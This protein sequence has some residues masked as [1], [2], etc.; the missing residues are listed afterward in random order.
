MS[1]D[2]RPG[3][4]GLALAE[5]SLA[6]V[7]LAVVV[8][9]GRLYDGNDHLADLVTFT[10]VAHVLAAGT[11]RSRLSTPVTAAIG[12]AGAVLV[13]TWLLFGAT[14]RFGL[15]T[16]ATVDAVG[17]ALDEAGPAFR[18][19]KAP[20]EVLVGFQLL[21]G[22]ALWGAAWFADWAAFRLRVAAEA[23]APAMILFVF[24]TVL[25]ADEGRFAAAVLFG[26][27]VV[28]FV[29]N[30][31]AMVAEG[32]AAWMASTPAEGARAVRRAAIGLGAAAVVLGAL[33]APIGPGYRDEPLVQWREGTGAGA[34]R[35]TVSPIV[36]LRRR[37]VSQSSRELFEVESP[38]AAYWRLT[39]L[40]QFDG[41]IWSSG[42]DFG[43]ADETLE[44][45]GPVAADT[46]VFTQQVRV[47]GLAAIW[48]PAAYQARVLHATNRPVRWNA[49]SSTLIV[50]ASS[51]SSDGL[52]Y[53]VTSARPVLDPATLERASGPDPDDVAE[54]YLALPAD[55]P[56]LAAEEARAAVAGATTRYARARALQDHFQGGSFTYTTDVE[57][58]HG[59]DALVAFLQDR[60]GYCEQ[61]AGAYAAM[62]R[63]LG[64]PARVAV[65]FTPGRRDPLDP[66]VFTV[67]GIHA[68]AW[69][70]V[71]FPD[72]GW[73]P[74]EPTPGRGIP[75]AE[76]HT[77]LAPDQE[78][79]GGD[80]L[81]PATTSTTST[82][83]APT[84]T[85]APPVAPPPAQDP[86]ELP[87]R[88]TVVG[89]ERGTSDRS[90]TLAAVLGGLVV[91][92]MLVVLAG[93]RLVRVA[94]R[95]AHRPRA[96]VL[97]AWRDAVTAVRWLTGHRP[98]ASE[99]HL[100]FASR[101]RNDLDDRAPE[102]VA[103]FDAL[104]ELASRA[105]WDVAP[106]SGD[107]VEQATRQAHAL[108]AGVRRRQSA[109]QRV[110]RRLSWRE[111]FDRVP[112]AE[113]A[114]EG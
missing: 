69:P 85:S 78:E 5:V 31:R 89:S 34:V 3:Q 13:S 60:R 100:E 101:V 55:F 95:D 73:V 104:A 45:S 29:A 41:E 76:R 56:E 22:L 18:T 99:T 82:T 25:G 37:L 111:A 20:T 97:G 10:L 107:D 24:C 42:G 4:G 12:V 68:H 64:I 96:T 113:P 27:A 39:S 51:P 83:A 9:F 74:F 90:G 86:G 23:L 48:V 71:Y 35:T 53:Q 1:T 84:P 58:G 61:F 30:H 44:T 21:A 46:E 7:H 75:G 11:R 36:D 40:H 102:L 59:N 66:T 47:K 91:L 54:R 32:A 6:A 16:A 80:A 108:T 63:S 17:A 109:A 26:G 110:R 38:V 15:P 79:A 70:E 2:R 49:D 67:Q 77:G 65:G 72:V 112:P 52:T 103:P 50:D 62:A 105:A 19:V 94:R 106:P 33:V 28:L 43:V 98:R 93:P 92:A 14:T 114:T 88:G 87:V 8:G 81:E 57:P